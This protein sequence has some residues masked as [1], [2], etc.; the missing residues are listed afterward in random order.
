MYSFMNPRIPLK[1][2]RSSISS[3]RPL[4]SL[5]GFLCR[6]SVS[7]RLAPLVFHPTKRVPFLDSSDVPLEEEFF[8]GPNRVAATYFPVCIGD[9]YQDGRYQVL[10]KLGFGRTSTVWLARDL[11]SGKHVVLKVFT[12][13]ASQPASSEN[14]DE[15]PAASAEL[16]ALE[17]LRAAG[18]ADPARAHLRG[19]IDT[20]TLSRSQGGSGTGSEAGVHRVLV[21]QPML[22]SWRAR[23]AR[24]K[25]ASRT[26]HSELF[27]GFTLQEIKHAIRNISASN[28]LLGVPH[29]A[30]E[31]VFS[32]YV[33][34][35]FDTPSPRKRL[36][37][38]LPAHLVFQ[39]RS[40]SL[41]PSFSPAFSR[42]TIC[43][44]DFGSACVLPT[45]HTLTHLV[46][47]T[48]YRAPEVHLGLP[49]GFAIDIWNIVLVAWRMVAGRHLFA[50]HDAAG[51]F[52]PPV[53]LAQ[54][55]KVLGAPP[56]GMAVAKQWGCGLDEGGSQAE[57]LT[58]RLPMLGGVDRKDFVAFMYAGLKW[59]PE[60][61]K[62]ARELLEEPWLQ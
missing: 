2:L 52:R 38:S 22:E 37:G 16:V 45:G 43:L 53:A 29:G 49:W 33:T 10:G 54:M 12:L 21:Q 19:A 3:T 36:G 46:Q 7:P 56:E 40:L 26:S 13:S 1:P 35:E 18:L 28:I 60:E 17:L 42:Y 51:H 8:G 9:V 41:P 39:S 48:A 59:R 44:S 62:T 31:L 30:E 20:L 24:L 58:D 14:R 15:A 25:S 27:G 32:A 34:R 47:P 57:T 23:A 55:I 6:K 11:Y 5:H 50:G 4:I 61:R